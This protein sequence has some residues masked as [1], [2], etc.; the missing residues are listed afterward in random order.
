MNRFLKR[1][2]P[3][4]ITGLLFLLL[5]LLWLL[6]DR[7]KEGESREVLSP[8]RVEKARRGTLART[9]LVTGTVQSDNQITLV[10]RIPGR[11]DDIL[12]TTGETVREGQEVALIDPEGYRLSLMQARASWEAARSTYERLSALYKAGAASEEDYNRAKAQYDA[13]N[14]QYELAR[15]QFGYT[16]LTS[17]IEGTVLAEHI[18]RGAMAGTDTPVLTIG[19]LRDLTVRTGVPEIYLP[20]F[21]NGE[22]DRVN[23]VTSPALE[24]ESFRA[25]LKSVAPYVSPGTGQFVVTLTLEENPLLK[26][27]MLLAVVYNLE[28]RENRL[29]LPLEAVTEDGRVWFVDGD[30]K[31]QPLPYG[32]I[33]ETEEFCALP[34]GWGDYD[35]I[36][37]GQN[38]LVPG[39]RVRILDGAGP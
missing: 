15:L 17:P 8:V 20:L 5:I 37:E 22:E 14:S 1:S 26:P 25:R 23:G 38:F 39:Q 30:G 3:Y 33:F 35:F 4:G 11:I 6:P 19:S 21:L 7:G 16:R 36:V 29:Y 32:E 10:P 31:A 27:G 34:D 13:L 18:N 12:V 28:V 24:G 9:V 2:L